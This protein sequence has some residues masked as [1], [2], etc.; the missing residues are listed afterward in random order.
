MNTP[1]S[2]ED[3]RSEHPLREAGIII[4]YE[5]IL[6]KFP[7]RHSIISSFLHREGPS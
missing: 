4:R 7:V 6:N 5:I 1:E 3:I 2:P